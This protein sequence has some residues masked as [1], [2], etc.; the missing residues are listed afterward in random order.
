M[1]RALAVSC[2]IFFFKPFLA[3]K[4]FKCDIIKMDIDFFFVNDSKP[5]DSKNPRK[6]YAWQIYIKKL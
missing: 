4:Y 2:Q 6:Y 5:R 1:H 3:G